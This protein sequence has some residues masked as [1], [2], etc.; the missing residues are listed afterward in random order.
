MTNRTKKNK[1]NWSDLLAQKLV[2]LRLSEVGFRFIPGVFPTWKRMKKI[3][4]AKA[5]IVKI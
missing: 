3:I 2:E 5:R 4:E 1:Y